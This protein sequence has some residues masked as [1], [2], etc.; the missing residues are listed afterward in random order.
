VILSAMM[1]DGE[2]YWSVFFGKT[3]NFTGEIFFFAQKN[4]DRYRLERI[5]LL[6]DN[7]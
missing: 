5:S 3:D 2:G 6:Q 1:G 4:I 7:E